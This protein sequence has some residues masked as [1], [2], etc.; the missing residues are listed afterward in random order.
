VS[1]KP[2]VVSDIPPSAERRMESFEPGPNV[3]A[4]WLDRLLEVMTQL[5]IELGVEGALG[6][7]LDVINDLFPDHAVGARVMDGPGRPLVV[8]RAPRES[9]PPSGPSD[10]A[11]LFPLHRFERVIPI[12]DHGVSTLHV[13]HDDLAAVADGSIEARFFDRAASALSGALHHAVLLARSHGA[14]EDLRA[15]QAQVVQ[16][17]KLASLGQIAAGIVHE[18]NNPLTSIVAYS[19]YLRKKGERTGMD[20]EDVE[21]L[22]RI[23]EAAD[24]IL[25]FSRDLVDYARPSPGVPGP[26]ALHDVIDQALV[27]CEHLLGKTGIEVE[28]HYAPEMRQVLGVGGELT[29]VFV[30][31]ITNACHAMTDVGGRLSIRTTLGVT[32]AE[33]EVAD[34]GHGIEHDHLTRI[35]EPFF[36][37][38]TEGRGT[39]LGL[40][41]VRNIVTC[42]GGSIRV[43]SEGKEG[44]RF[45]LTLPLALRGDLQARFVELAPRHPRDAPLT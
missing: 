3:P 12:D 22:R 29:Q 6:A 2:V 33:I 5:P 14:S 10:A 25:R 16:T 23:G 45:L 42:H 40:S 34:S 26:V 4:S 11:R 31:L 36:T 1:P 24:R 17:E 15:L 43:E 18:L 39:G 37:T 27:F 9:S 30:N 13:A 8:T 20:G 7:V 38:K 35:F 19:D 28:R 41:I 21:R 32:V 44:A